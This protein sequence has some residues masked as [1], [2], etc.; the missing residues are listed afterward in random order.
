ML[1]KFNNKKGLKKFHTF[2]TMY[3]IIIRYFMKFGS[4]SRLIKCY[5]YLSTMYRVDDSVYLK[6][7]E[8]FYFCTR[9]IRHKLTKKSK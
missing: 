1:I 3:K 9:N 7:I 2:A 4:T 8:P 5:I 6:L